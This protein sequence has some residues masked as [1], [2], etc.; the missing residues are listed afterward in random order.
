MKS[1]HFT[2]NR[3]IGDGALVRACQDGNLDK[4]VITALSNVRLVTAPDWLIRRNRA[5]LLEVGLLMLRPSS[6]ENSPASFA[7]V[8]ATVASDSPSPSTVAVRV[9]SR[10]YT[11]SVSAAC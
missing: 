4:P 3:D 10:P 1:V 6:T 5:T 11:A 8:H 7:A 2:R 9:T